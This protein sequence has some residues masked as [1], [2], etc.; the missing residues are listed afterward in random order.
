MSK[1]N[2]C[3][4]YSGYSR[5]SLL[6]IAISAII[7]IVTTLLT[8]TAIIPLTPAFLWVLL[9]IAVVYLAVNL[10]AASTFNCR[11]ACRCVKIPLSFVLTGILGTI[12]LSIILLGISFAATS[13]LGAILTGVLLFFFSLF[14]TSTACLARCLFGFEEDDYCDISSSFE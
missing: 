12:F 13:V 7:G 10:I 11:N 4:S 8:I 6:S 14:I 2:C 9:G 1:M 3:C 5:C